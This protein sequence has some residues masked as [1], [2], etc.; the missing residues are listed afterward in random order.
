MEK[1]EE[2]LHEIFINVM[3]VV[4]AKVA[5]AEFIYSFFYRISFCKAY[6]QK[7]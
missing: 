1:K 3:Y 7:W 2:Q 5:M 4:V 6:I